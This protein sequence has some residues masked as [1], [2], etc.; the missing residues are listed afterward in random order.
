MNKTPNYQLSQ[1]E[2]PDPVRMD[3]FNAD[4]RK[5]DDELARLRENVFDLTYYIGLQSLIN[6][7][8]G[9][10]YN[11]TN[12]PI[13]TM[14]FRP[15]EKYQTTD[16]ITV[17][18]H[19]AIL[20]GAGATGSITIKNSSWNVVCPRAKETRLW[21]HVDG[22]TIA[23]AFNGSPMRKLKDFMCGSVASGTAA[24]KPGQ[25]RH[26]FVLD[27]PYTDSIELKLD[28]TC[29]NSGT[30]IVSDIILAQF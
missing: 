13:Y 19:Q 30:M 14:S 7:V 6:H 11:Y 27:R 10:S 1:W 2:L 24:A 21:V 5:L 17:A 12:F 26:V 23:A 20:T 3:D 16:G 8:A 18:N 28:L 4:N 29:G 9:V 25:D 22:G 15:G